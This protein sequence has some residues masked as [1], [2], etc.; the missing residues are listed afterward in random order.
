MLH[1]EG[2][3]LWIERKRERSRGDIAIAFR[4]QRI[5]YDVLADRITLLSSALKKRGVKP[6]DRVAYLGN[7]HPAFLEVFFATA[8][9]GA[10][11]V[12]LNTRLAAP[13]LE[14]MLENSRAKA[15]IF[16]DELR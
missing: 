10:I 2:I 5:T 14:F 16:H 7:N 8:R 1:N 15:L 12:P 11:F 4:D 9:I 6:R 3:G 13:E